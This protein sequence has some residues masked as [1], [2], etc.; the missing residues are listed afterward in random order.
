M[1]TELKTFRC[2]D[3]GIMHTRLLDQ[4]GSTGKISSRLLRDKAKHETNV[5]LDPLPDQQ[6]STDL[7][8]WELHARFASQSS[9][10]CVSSSWL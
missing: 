5:N 9:A 6:V 2:T 7:Y 4:C 3:A 8:L 10:A 1:T